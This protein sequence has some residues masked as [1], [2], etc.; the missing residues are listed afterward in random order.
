LENPVL[1]AYTVLIIGAGPAGLFAARELADRGIR[2][3]VLNRD[4]KPGGLAEYGIFPDKYKMKDG[5]RCQFKQILASDLVQ[6]Y[7]N[8]QVNQQGDVKLEQLREMG[9]NAILIAAGAQ[10]TKRLGIPG[11]DLRGVYHAKDLV[12]HY[13]HLPP[14]SQ[15]HF[16]IG[17]RIGVIG[18]GNVMADIAHYLIGYLHAQEVIAIARRG[19]GEIKFD[20]KEIEPIAANVDVQILDEEIERAAPLMEAIGQDPQR[21]KAFL[22]AA[23]EKAQPCCSNT[24]FMLRFLLS[25]VRIL[26]DGN[27]RVCGVE[28]E[29]NT[30]VKVNEEVKARGTGRKMTIDLDTVIFAIGDAVDPQLGLPVSGGEFVKNPN[31][32]FPVEG[33]SY[34][35]YDPESNE[36]LEGLFVAGWARQA[37]TGLVGITRRDGSNAARA[38]L[39]YLQNVQPAGSLP[40]ENMRQVLDGLQKPVVTK[41]DLEILEQVER[42][43]AEELGLMEFK[44]DTNEE[45]LAAIGKA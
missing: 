6:Y 17:Q 37:S 12:Y 13:N 40:L 43:R 26:G 5:L 39:Q 4:I 33:V 29:Q 2:V 36:P 3:V 27:G 35:L 31:P 28:L 15:M 18:V 19:P 1:S 32:R 10:G 9:F 20:R 23:I 24:H 34:E 16:E 25:P 30:L 22:H 21:T 38:I 45:M 11:E 14:F 7:G 41:G 44:F 42:K 8:V